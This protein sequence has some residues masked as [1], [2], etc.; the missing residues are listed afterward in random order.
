MRPQ[1]IDQAFVPAGSLSSQRSQ[2]GWHFRPTSG[3][4]DEVDNIILLTFLQKAVS[5]HHQVEILA[6]GL[7]SEAANTQQ[8]IAT[9]NA[10]GSRDDR[11]HVELGPGFPPDQK[12]AQIFNHL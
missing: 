2:I 8:Q 4:G 1:S 3:I 6:D 12:S 9:K 11:Q 10:E 7:G 5:A